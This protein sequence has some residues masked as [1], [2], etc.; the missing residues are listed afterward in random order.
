VRWI[1][2]IALALCVL[3]AQS[4]ASADQRDPRLAYLFDQLRLAP[5]PQVA[6]VVAHNIWSIWGQADDGAVQLLLQ[7]GMSAMARRDLRGA[8]AKFNQIIAIAPAFAEGWN[9]R[10]TVHYLLGSYKESLADI[11]RT[12]ALEPRHFGALS[13]R[14][15]VYMEL[16]DEDLALES[17]EQALEVYPLLPG[18]ARNAEILRG[19]LG[20]KDI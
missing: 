1:S 13:G 8:L 16:E 2:A 3:G 5:D 6:N 17:F 20:R 7:D 18:A 9:K 11:E 10:A 4:P 14:G 15:L 12:L 19:R